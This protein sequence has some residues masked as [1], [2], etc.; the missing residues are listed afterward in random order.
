MK[1]SARI[2]A[3]L[4]TFSLALAAPAMAGGGAAPDTLSSGSQMLLSELAGRW[5]WVTNTQIVFETDGSCRAYQADRQVNTCQVAVLDPGRR[6]LRITHA[7]GG[8]ID[9]VTLS[10]DTSFLSHRDTVYVSAFGSHRLWTR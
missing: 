3:L 7:I 2:Y 5:S 6:L 9:T 1:S 10:P 4:T 8:W